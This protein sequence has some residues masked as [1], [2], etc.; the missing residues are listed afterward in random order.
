MTVTTEGEGSNTK[1]EES[2][3]S[4]EPLDPSSTAKA[5]LHQKLRA[6]EFEIGAVSST[7]RKPKKDGGGEGSSERGVAEGDAPGGGGGDGSSL[8]R[9][10]AADRLR[11]LK[12]TRAK[13]TNELSSLCEKNTKAQLEEELANLRKTLLR[14]LVKEDTRPKKKLKEDKKLTKKS[15][16]RVKTV[17]FNDDADF[18]AVLD[19]ASAGFVETVSYLLIFAAFLS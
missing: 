10:L 11:S 15:G 9:A 4:R 17:S 8:Q 7:I 2:S 3:H 6:V 18:D 5:E 12:N 16:K 1:E 13:L 19:A 14:S